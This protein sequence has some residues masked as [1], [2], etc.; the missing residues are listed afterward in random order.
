MTMKRSLQILCCFFLLTACNNS[1][2]N[3]NKTKTRADSLMDQVMEGHN[4]G[5]AKMDKI[6]ASQKKVQQA[7]DSISKLPGETQKAAASYKYQL[8]SLLDRLKYAEYAMDKWMEEFNMDSSLD[9]SEERIKYLEA[10]KI[11]VE[12]VKEAM[13]SSLAKTDSLFGKKQ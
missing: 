6:G 7:I 11:K 10:E 3:G 5:M 4:I 12:K 9:N 1:A 2:D 13:V 8:D